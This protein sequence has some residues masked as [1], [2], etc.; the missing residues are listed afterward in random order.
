[1]KNVIFFFNLFS[2]VVL[3]GCS[4]SATDQGP[5]NKENK[6]PSPLPTEESSTDEKKKTIVFFGNSLS[7]GLGVAPEESF[8]GLIEKRIDSLGLPYQV[9]NAGLSGETTAGGDARIDWILRQPVDILVL[10]L[11]G[12][13]GLRG[14]K[15]QASLENLQ[16]I[17]DKTKAKYPDAEIIIAGMQAPPNMGA[18]F[19]SQFRAV[20][21]RLADENNAQLIPFLLEGVGGV[22]SLNQADGI[23]PTPEGHRIVADNVWEILG[24][25]LN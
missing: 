19:T 11:G 18:E 10:E 9:I 5:E 4:G 22:P 7:A 15:P 13:D 24:P 8:P 1:M 17:I 25:M 6:T 2:F 20:F 3:L 16:S 12:N 23:H 21:P 14:I